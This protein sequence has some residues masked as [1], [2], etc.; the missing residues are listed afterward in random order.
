MS[1]KSRPHI[2]VCVCTYKR[3]ALLPDLIRAIE[4]QRTDGQF[5]YEVIV[6]DNDVAR[7]AESIVQQLAR[8]ATIPISYCLEPE[9][10]I[11]LARN[12]AVARA[13]GDFVVFI[14]DD[15]VPTS[16]WLYELLTTQAAYSAD[17]VL[18]PVVSR[19]QQKPPAWVTKGGF[20]D[21][22]RHPTGHLVQ[23]PEA[24]TGNVLL[25]RKSMERLKPPF[26]PQFGSGG[27]DVDFF[28]RLAEQGG[29]LV[30]S[31]EAVAYEL[32]PPYRCTRRFLAGRAL[33][34]GSNFPKQSGQRARNVLKSLIAVPC[35]TV[36]LPVLA[37][38]GHHMFIAYAMKLLEHSSRLLSL[39]GVQLATER[40]T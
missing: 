5:T 9:M 37:L 27:E 22:P 2:S 13:T 12:A 26:R 7:S 25:V 33:L 6:A 19:F 16:D 34:R 29:V 28:R 14:D 21:R 38:I 11:A 31:N 17:A 10:N 39:A 20:F 18:G 8:A 36:A 24:R 4:T 40:Q 3:A 32:V 23:W 1:T 30:W 35:Y 15:E